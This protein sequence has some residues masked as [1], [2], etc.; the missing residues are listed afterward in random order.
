MCAAGNKEPPRRAKVMMSSSAPASPRRVDS[1]SEPAA[2]AAGSL[3]ESTN[4]LRSTK[5]REAVG[6]A[7][8]AL[9]APLSATESREGLDWSARNALYDIA[10]LQVIATVSASLMV[11]LAIILSVFVLLRRLRAQL[12]AFV[13]VD[14]PLPAPPPQAEP[15][16]AREAVADEPAAE[17]FDLGLTYEE[18]RR[19]K[20]E[21]DRQ[22]EQAVLRTIFED[23]IRLR[24]QLMEVEMAAA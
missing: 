5:E 17:T 21:A 13:R 19:L 2:S 12:P 16:L 14:A 6:P 24:Q 9:P 11:S 3:A 10:V 15:P 1:A 20:E 22:H 8:P 18:E 23:N 4:S 7:A